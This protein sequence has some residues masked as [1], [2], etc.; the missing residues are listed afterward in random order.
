MSSTILLEDQWAL[1][2]QEIVKK[3]V[4]CRAK[5]F[6]V[7]VS[8]MAEL[9]HT[10]MATLYGYTLDN[11]TNTFFPNFLLLQ[12]RKNLFETRSLDT[13]YVVAGLTQAQGAAETMLYFLL[14]CSV[15]T[16]NSLLAVSKL[17]FGQG[18]TEP[19]CNVAYVL[20][21]SLNE[22]EAKFNALTAVEFRNSPYIFITVTN[23]TR[24]FVM[25]DILQLVTNEGEN[26]LRKYA[27]GKPVNLATDNLVL[28]QVWNRTVADV[29]AQ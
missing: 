18:A 17:L 6:G 2:V 21:R 7:S 28:L 24:W 12:A 3:A 11:L 22:V 29:V 16:S 26:N 8:E 23:I 15:K 4:Q 1:F 27:F 10:D 25:D 19:T 14:V 13:S 5:T 9:L 20:S